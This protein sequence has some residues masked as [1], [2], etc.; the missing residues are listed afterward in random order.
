MILF[1]IKICN[2]EEL[3]WKCLFCVQF[4]KTLFMG[5]YSLILI[6]WGISYLFT[7]IFMRRE[8]ACQSGSL[9]RRAL[10]G[11]IAIRQIAE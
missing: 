9:L 3:L 8:E 11:P 5:R 2:S 1:L 4:Y 10:P 7:L 6:S